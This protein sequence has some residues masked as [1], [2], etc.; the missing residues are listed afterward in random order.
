MGVTDP[1]GFKDGGKAGF[2]F[3]PTVNLGHILTFLSMLGLAIGVYA[4]LRS[5]IRAQAAKVTAAE[6]YF[7]SQ[8]EDGRRTTT[9]LKEGIDRVERKVDTI[10]TQTRR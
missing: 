6:K 2:K 4:D 3:D 8:I 1:Q 10:L 5:D 7:D 9:I